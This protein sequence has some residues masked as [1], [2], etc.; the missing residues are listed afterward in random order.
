MRR[1]DEEAPLYVPTAFEA[2]HLADARRTVILSVLRHGRAPSS[3]SS[4]GVDA[5]RAREIALILHL[6]ALTIA[7]VFTAVTGTWMAGILVLLAVTVSL[8]VT[9]AMLARLEARR[10]GQGRRGPGQ[11]HRQ[12]E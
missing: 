11:G 12:L 7:L 10:P 9:V 8:G 5:R 3:G 4:R 2:D 1:P 6:A